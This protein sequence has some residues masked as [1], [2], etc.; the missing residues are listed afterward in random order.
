MYWKVEGLMESYAYKPEDST[1]KEITQC[2]LLYF[3]PTVNFVLDIIVSPCMY[4]D[5]ML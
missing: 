2:N 1:L 5:N 3:F 4:L